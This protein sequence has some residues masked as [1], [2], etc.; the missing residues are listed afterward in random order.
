MNCDVFIT[1]AVTGAGDT[2]GRSP[3]VPVTPD[4]IAAAAIEAA[5]AGAAIA[6]I[7]V[8]DP[9]TGRGAR[10]PRLYREVVERV[11]AADVDVVLN[12]T[13]GM[14]GDL[15]LGGE[16]AP[17]PHDAG[18]HRHGRRGGAAGARRGPPARRSARSTAA[19]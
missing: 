5:R 3:L 19:R 18:R 10:D 14:G 8:R 7:H 12:L 9:E 6:H 15:V 16:D 13:A 4:Q 2:A 17:L 1:C 11:R